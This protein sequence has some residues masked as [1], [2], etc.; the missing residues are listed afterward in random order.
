MHIYIYICIYISAVAE[1]GPWAWCSAGPQL[2]GMMSLLPPP[3]HKLKGREGA[4]HRPHARSR[5]LRKIRQAPLSSQGAPATAWS[6]PPLSA[7]LPAV[8]PCAGTARRGSSIHWGLIRPYD[9]H[10]EFGEHVARP[11][12]EA[13]RHNSVASS[14]WQRAEAR[15]RSRAREPD[16]QSAS[17]PHQ[18]SDSSNRPWSWAPQSRTPRLQ[19]SPSDPHH[20]VTQPRG[21]ARP[22][23]PS[24]RPPA[25][26]A[27][28]TSGLC[29]ATRRPHQR[30]S[31]ERGLLQAFYSA[32]CAKQKPANSRIPRG[33]GTRFADQP[34]AP[35]MTTN[36][37][38]C[39]AVRTPHTPVP[40]AP[41]PRGTSQPSHSWASTGGNIIGT[42]RGQPCAAAAPG[43]SL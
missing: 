33:R 15:N 36:P 14:V 16:A 17:C 9:A 3:N 22:G 21:A 8:S 39:T 26:S 19:P 37:G 43:P 28:T 42:I 1:T 41:P 12:D 4:G 34:G 11:R 29:S 20:H 13:A 40:G 2:T 30:I 5:F 18:R 6:R 25:R 38:R 24:P 35:T 31:A 23:S 7:C 32:A 27:A 10:A